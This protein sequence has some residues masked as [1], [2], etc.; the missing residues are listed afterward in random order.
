M[1]IKYYF[2]DNIYKYGSILKMLNRGA[3]LG[4]LETK[5][6]G[7]YSDNSPLEELRFIL[8]LIFKQNSDISL[9][10]KKLFFKEQ[11]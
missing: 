7:N 9:Q 3:L 10:L 4:K 6:L 1:H 11:F 2:N 5:A 8:K